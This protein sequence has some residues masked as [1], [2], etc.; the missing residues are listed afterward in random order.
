MG[1]RTK[2]IKEKTRQFSPIFLSFACS[3]RGE[4]HRVAVVDQNTT[5][6]QE[7]PLFPS[8]EPINNILLH[9]VE[10]VAGNCSLTQT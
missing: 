8:Q 6:L 4:L 5:L 1:R 10:K 2:K 9:E 7:I 3:D